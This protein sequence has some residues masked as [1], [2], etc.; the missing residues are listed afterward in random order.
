MSRSNPTVENPATKFFEWD[1][2]NGNIKYWDKEQE[3][4]ITVDLPF[5]FLM[6]DMLTT[7]KGFHNR[8]ESGIYSNEVRSLDQIIKVKAFEGGLIAE[9]KYDNIKDTIKAAG[10]KFAKSIYIGY[11]ENGTMQI[12]NITFKG[13]SLGPWI[14]LEKKVGRRTLEEKAVVITDSRHESNGSIEYEVPVMKVRNVKPESNKRAIALDEKLQEYLEK[15]T[16]HV[17]L[18]S[19]E[20]TEDSSEDWATARV[21]AGEELYDDSDSEAPHP[22]GT[23]DLDE[24]NEEEVDLPF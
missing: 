6:L 18:P 10:G 4:E 21:N 15:K 20:E 1:A 24:E 3:R 2:K 11:N 19:E 14:D 13:A 12:G 16:D 7:I 8:S 5:H 23:V 17:D 22:A 9:G